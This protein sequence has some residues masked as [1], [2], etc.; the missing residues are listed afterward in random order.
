MN[1]QKLDPTDFNG[2]RME[3]AFQVLIEEINDIKDA[4]IMEEEIR[5][6]HPAL[7]DAYEKYQILFELTKNDNT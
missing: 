5:N 6:T 2:L 7:R 3:D 1:H 4:L